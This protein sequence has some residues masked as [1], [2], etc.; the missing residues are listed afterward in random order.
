MGRILVALWV[1]LIFVGL[2]ASCGGNGGT[3]PPPDNKDFSLSISP[4]A[5]SVVAGSS[6]TAT[7]TVTAINS[8]AGAVTI[9]VSGLPAG[10]TSSPSSP[11]TISPGAPQTL[12]I[13]I[14]D[15][16]QA[17]TATLSLS[18]TAGS[19]QHSASASVAIST[20]PDFSIS[21]SPAQVAANAGGTS[22]PLTVSIAGISGFTDN[23]VV[24]LS[25]LPPGAV[26]LPAAP[27]T[28]SPG[29]TQSFTVS[30]PQSTTASDYSVEANAVAGSLTHSAQFTLRCQPAVTITTSE[31]DTMIF[32]EAS[33]ADG[34]AR[35]GLLKKWGAAISEA[36]LNGVNFVNSDDPGREIQ[37]SLW[38]GNDTYSSYWGYNPIEAGD[39]D[40]QGSP[41]LATTIAADSIYTK[42]QPIQWAPENFGGGYGNPVPGDAYVEKWITVVPGYSTVFK[43]HYR[44]THFGTDS[45]AAAMQELPVAYVNPIVST[46]V[47][48]AGDAPWAG[49]ALSTYNMP[50]SCCDYVHTPEQWGAYV[51]VTNSGLTLYCPGQ[52]PLAKGFNAGA[53]LQLT[54]I[55]PYSW[56]PGSVLEFDAYILLGPVEESR[57][58]VYQIHSQIPAGTPFP[59]L[60]YLDTGSGTLQGTVVLQ[61]WTWSPAGI[62]TV[63]VFI[64][65]TK[66]GAATYG[67]P[68]QDV[69]AA[70]PGIPANVGFEYSLDTTTL[71]NGAHDIVVKATDPT[72]KVSTF[73]TKHAN[74]SN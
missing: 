73:A 39:H 34:T 27:F 15:N 18:A 2:T 66:I 11:F 17:G 19:L 65:G 8:F 67:T 57:T 26:T 68:R 37:T 45:H 47:Y 10:A 40:F 22:T 58:A 41:V 25:G 24:S 30:V 12:T 63:D 56:D 20:K 13:T 74:V 29:H 69:A 5:I 49:G 21:I 36:S 31:T 42:T 23:V 59:P 64:D 48:Y 6:A 51:D 38:D 1:A 50:Y 53:T 32:L 4:S 44:I 52:F 3:Q 71:P 35:I 55:S 72:G 9:S 16:A 28:I 7:L 70:L 62:A 54:P 46:F 14:A 33:G 61:G 60:G 43:V